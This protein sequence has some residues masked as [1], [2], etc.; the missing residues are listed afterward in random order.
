MDSKQVSAAASQHRMAAVPESEHEELVFEPQPSTR[1]YQGWLVVGGGDRGGGSA[2]GDRGGGCAGGAPGS[3]AAGGGARGE[4][5]D[6]GVRAGGGATGVGT[7]GEGGHT[8]GGES[9]G[10]AG[11]GDGG[12]G[13]G[14]GDGGSD[15]GSGEDCESAQTCTSSSSTGQRLAISPVLSPLWSVES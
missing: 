14:G 11:G 4:G 10:G 5:G 7:R 13:D 9:G 12:D 8:G 2:G 1:K 6:E 3:G 15:G